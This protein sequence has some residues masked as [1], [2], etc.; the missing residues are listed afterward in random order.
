MLDSAQGSLVD[1]RG[2][3]YLQATEQGVGKQLLD[4]KTSLGIDSCCKTQLDTQGDS[5]RLLRP[6]MKWESYSPPLTG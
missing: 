3:S 2:L 4:V 6:V 1:E 5:W